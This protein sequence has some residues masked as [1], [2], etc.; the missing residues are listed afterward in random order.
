MNVGETTKIVVTS[1]TK[2]L[3]VNYKSFD[4]SVAT[5][6]STGTIK[7]LKKGS[8]YLEVNVNEDS[9]KIIELVVT[10]STTNNVNNN[11]SNNNQNTNS[12]TSKDNNQSTD[13]SDKSNSN[14]TPTKPSD[15]NNNSSTTNDSNQTTDNDK[16]DI[17]NQLSKSQMKEGIL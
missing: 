17:L 5:V 2:N 16:T 6:T 15:S 11:S 13:T 12:S 1:D 9:S 8:T 7:A 3:K 14:N 10:N 4:K